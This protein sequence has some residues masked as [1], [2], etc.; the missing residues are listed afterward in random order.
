VAALGARRGARREVVDEAAR[1]LARALATPALARARRAV[2]LARDVPVAVEADG[3]V[4]ADRLDL[5]FEEP[6]GLVVVRTGSALDGASPALPAEAIA[7]TF[8]RPVREVLALDLTD[9]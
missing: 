6:E 3:A 2:W 1:L 4:V 5:L 7:T 9:V 8:G